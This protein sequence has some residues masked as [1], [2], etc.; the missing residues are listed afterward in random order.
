MNSQE[1]LR[2]ALLG[3]I[4]AQY[5]AKRKHS[6]KLYEK[7][8]HCLPGGD[9]RTVTYHRPFPTFMSYGKGCHL[10]DEDGNEYL[11]FFNNA[12]SL[13]LGHAHPKV[14]QAVRH[15][16]GR[17]SIFASPVRS[18]IELAELI[19]RRLPSVDRVR[20]CNSGT[21][22]AMAAVRVARAYRKKYRILKME[23]GYHGSYDLAEISIKPDLK[24]AGPLEEPRSVPEDVSVSPGVVQ[25]CIV[26][27]FNEPEIASRLI[28]AHQGGLA[29][30][31]VEP[32]QGSCG[33]IPA[34][35]EF[36]RTLRTACSE[37]DIPLIFDEVQS[38]RVAPG[39]CQEMFGVAAD[40]TVLGKII[41]G[42]YPVGAVAG[43]GD[44]MEL[45]S[46]LHQPS[47]THSGTFNGN[48]V[49]MV[50]GTATL[51]EL[52]AGEIERINSLG[53]L[54]RTRIRQAL[55][56]AGL[57][58]QVV[59]I[60]SMA[61]IHFTNE[62]VVS[63]RQSARGRSDVREIVHLLLMNRGIFASKRSMFNISTP[64]SESEVEKAVEVLSTCLE[65]IKDYVRKVHPDLATSRSASVP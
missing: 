29:A 37:H 2:T 50:A 41:G 17:G 1:A 38:F 21:E 64:M 39:G 31:L 26:A 61:Q 6:K 20:F 63:W 18:Q 35:V 62:R 10:F 19:R 8:I 16:A 52:T 3:E 4:Y 65:E 24:E 7:A 36:L 23:G 40:L 11:D 56:E 42:G 46:P 55:L 49:T 54:L 45:F 27:P 53:E 44:I 30:V 22:A 57:V 59:G 5:E 15:Q 9:T 43:R 14:V 13:V 28:E 60:G 25:D 34:T 51:T 33:M 48:P 32:M 58:A 12:T 47:L